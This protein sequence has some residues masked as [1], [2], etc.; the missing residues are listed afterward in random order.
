ML[1]V[2]LPWR[3][4]KSLSSVGVGSV[5]SI[6]QLTFSQEPHIGIIMGVLDELSAVNGNLVGV[7]KHGS[8]LITA[9]SHR[10]NDSM[11]GKRRTKVNGSETDR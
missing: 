2:R 10:R 5:V 8:C 9:Q 4:P 3:A 1:K 6:K 11:D 7:I